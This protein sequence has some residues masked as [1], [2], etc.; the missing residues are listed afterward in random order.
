[1]FISNFTV[2]TGFRK[3]LL[4]LPNFDIH[5]SPYQAISIFQRKMGRNIQLLKTSSKTISLNAVIKFTREQG[6]TKGVNYPESQQ[7]ISLRHSIV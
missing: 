7:T 2:V 3:F 4:T 1:M 6:L 5:A